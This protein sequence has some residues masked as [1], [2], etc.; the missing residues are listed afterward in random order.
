MAKQNKVVNV[1]SKASLAGMVASAMLTS[2]AFAAVDAYT[3]KVGDDVFKYDKAELVAS[4]LDNS[5]GLDAP[6]SDL[7]T[8]IYI[9]YV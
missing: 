6:L 2:Q 1:L 9:N 4:F 8:V 5:E 7:R 3:V